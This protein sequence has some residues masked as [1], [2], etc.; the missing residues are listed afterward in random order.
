MRASPLYVNRAKLITSCNSILPSF[1]SL[2][3]YTRL[4]SRTHG[5]SAVALRIM[6]VPRKFCKRS[7]SPYPPNVCNT[8]TQLRFHGFA[9]LRARLRTCVRGVCVCACVRV[10]LPFG[11]RMTPFGRPSCPDSSRARARACACAMC[12]CTR[13]RDER[14]DEGGEGKG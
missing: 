6:A 11:L 13:L 5:C 9:Y 10:M 3:P 12:V 4:Y 1:S 14:L 7:F 8:P 2:S